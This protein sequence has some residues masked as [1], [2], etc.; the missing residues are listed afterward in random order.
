MAIK[1]NNVAGKPGPGRPKGSKDKIPRALK[2]R[3]L[4][5]W[6]RLEKR[7]GKSLLEVASKDPK[8]FYSTMVK[9]LLPKAV[10]IDGKF[11]V[12]MAVSEGIKRLLEDVYRRSKD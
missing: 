2:T 9:P 4:E 5:V 10:D 11:D 8:W 7:N 6:D 1:N 3:V 12:N